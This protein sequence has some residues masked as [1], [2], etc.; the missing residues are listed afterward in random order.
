MKLSITLHDVLTPKL[1][2]LAAKSPSFRDKALR[3]TVF[4]LMNKV[5]FRTPVDLGRARGGWF[6]GIQNLMAKGGG[7]GGIGRYKQGGTTEGYA[8]GEKEGRYSETETGGKKVIEITN[9]VS[10]IIFLEYGRS[11]QS[12]RGMVRVSI[13][14][15]KGITPDIF[16]REFSD[17]VKE[18][19]S[20]YR[21]Q[22]I[23]RRIQ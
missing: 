5:I 7:K 4:D 21:A 18:F 12:P 23:I 14:E 13:S 10:Y 15:M 16:K 9:A 3:K 2:K 8:Q 20:T 6:V 22:K 11:K 17:S 19:W 1:Q